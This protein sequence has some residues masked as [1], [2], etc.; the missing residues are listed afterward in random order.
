MNRRALFLAAAMGLITYVPA[1]ASP[2]S[3]CERLMNDALPIA[4]RML[5]ERGEFYPYGMT[6]DVSG[7]GAVVGATDGGERPKSAPLIEMLRAQF[8]DGAKAGRYLATA[9]VYDVRVVDPST[10]VKSDAMAVELD[11]RGGYS[12]IV[13]IPYSLRTGDVVEGRLFA[14]QGKARVFK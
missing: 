10:G 11:H 5:R 3:D 13:F 7:K 8:H 14:Q 12:V 6:L 9:L 1:M 2:K 4:K